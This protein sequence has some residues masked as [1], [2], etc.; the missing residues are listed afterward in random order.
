MLAGYDFYLANGTK[1]SGTIPT[2]T[3]AVQ[4]GAVVVPAGYIPT[5]QSF[6]VSSGVDVSDTTAMPMDVRSGAVFYDAEGTRTSGT[7]PSIGAYYITPTT[8]DQEIPDGVYI[9]GGIVIKGDANLL[10]ANIVQGVTIFGVTGTASGG[11]GGST[12]YYKCA[13]VNT[14]NNTWTGYKAVLSGGSYT[15]ESTVTTGLTY[16]AV[17]PEVG[18]IYADGALIEANLFTIPTDSLV[19]YAS[20]NGNTPAVA[21]T[22][23]AIGTIGSVNYGTVSGIPCADSDTTKTL[24]VDELMSQLDPGV[25]K[26]LSCWVYI[27]S[28]ND[29]NDSLTIFCCVQAGGGISIHLTSSEC[30]A[31]RRAGSSY[32]TISFGQLA[33]NT[34]YHLAVTDDGNIMRTYRNGTLITETQPTGSYSEAQ[35]SINAGITGPGD[36]VS[37]FVYNLIGYM[38]AYRIYNRVLAPVEITALA[39]EFTPTQS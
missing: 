36:S 10:A 34:W 4:G 15:F 12:D 3:A 22:G 13:S 33:L 31:E 26:T 6:P 5:S 23:Q 8:S 7:I 37:D 25:P 9:N 27:T 28:W 17:T 29:N 20:L 35:D 32:D 30:A 11:G 38:G 18:N 19:L 21:E 1:T 2:V 14:A 16:T 39:A 24:Y